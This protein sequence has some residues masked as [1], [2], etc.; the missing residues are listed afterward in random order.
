MRETQLLAQEFLDH[1]EEENK[2]ALMNDLLAVHQVYLTNCAT[3]FYTIKSLKYAVGSH[4]NQRKRTLQYQNKKNDEL[5]IHQIHQQKFLKHTYQF[6]VFYNMKEL[7]FSFIELLLELL[8]EEIKK[9][10]LA[11]SMQ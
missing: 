6:K 1:L 9:P 2:R 10:E 5:V 4:W 8:K 11:L 3:S 7:Q